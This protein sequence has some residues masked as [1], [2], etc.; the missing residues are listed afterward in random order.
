MLD[1]T[2]FTAAAIDPA[3]CRP[4]HRLRAALP[5]ARAALRKHETEQR[6]MAQMLDRDHLR[7]AAG[8]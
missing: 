2:E 7:H 6:R 8:R 3:R 5:R 4:A 1:L